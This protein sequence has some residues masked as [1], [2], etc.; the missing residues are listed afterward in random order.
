MTLLLIHYTPFYLLVVF[1]KLFELYNLKLNLD[2]IGYG[3]VSTQTRQEI[4][5]IALMQK[6]EDE[7]Y[8][9]EN[10]KCLYELYYQLFLLSAIGKSF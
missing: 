7:V 5:S 4:M 3:D 10:R 2:R 1:Q 6:C 8:K 9:L